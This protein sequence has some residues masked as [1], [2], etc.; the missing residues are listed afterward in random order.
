MRTVIVLAS[1]LATAPAHAGRIADLF[2]DGIFGL[3]W[4][5]S[6]EEIFDLFPGGI[7]KASGANT[8]YVVRDDRAVLGIERGRQD[9]ITFG[10]SSDERLQS[11][12]IQFP[13]GTD[14]LGLLVQRTQEAF[15]PFSVCQPSSSPAPSPTPCTAERRGHEMMTQIG[16]TFYFSARWQPDSGIVVFLFNETSAPALGRAKTSLTVFNRDFAVSE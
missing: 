9:E 14:T 13:G 5:A 7:W 8:E 16:D 2:G 3:P 6:R 4:G 10:L 11:V 15:G 1:L 12:S